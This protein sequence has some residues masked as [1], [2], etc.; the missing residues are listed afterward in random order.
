MIIM[1]YYGIGPTY[2]LCIIGMILCIAASSHVKST[3]KKFSRIRSYCGMTGAEAASKILSQNGFYDVSVNHIKGDLTDHYDPRTQSVNLS[4]SVYGSTSIAAIAVAAH[5]CGHVAQNHTDYV[6]LKLR[7]AL[8]PAA[9]IG[10]QIGLP[11]VIIGLIFSSGSFL[12]TLGIWIFSL[13]VIFQI[14]T[15]PVEFNASS[16]ALQTLEE[17][18]ILG[19]DENS[20][21]K[22]VLTAAALT[23]VA[24]AASSALQ[25]LRLVLL[26]NRRRD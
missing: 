11:L 2:I 21:A 17:Y 26:S 6:P 9:N 24:A 22:K 10:S 15:L 13:S 4:D 16:R 5:E 18:G 14:V 7:T 8:V 23:Y 3:F 1:Y 20:S 19:G 12:I 25:L